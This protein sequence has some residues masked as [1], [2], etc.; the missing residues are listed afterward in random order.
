[1]GIGIERMTKD[2][3]KALR[4]VD[5]ADC[6]LV[7][8]DKGRL[9]KCETPIG[10]SREH[11]TPLVIESGDQLL[12]LADAWNYPEA[13]EGVFDTIHTG[14][15]R[16]IVCVPD[17]IP[18]LHP[19]ACHERTV[20]LYRPW[21]REILLGAD[22]VLSISRAA[23]DDLVSVVADRNIPHRPGLPVDWFH[24]AS[25]FEPRAEVNV[26]EKIRQSFEDD[27]RVYLCVGT[28]EPRKGHLVAVEAFEKL[29]ADGASSR[30][31]FVG[32]RGWFDYALVARILQHPEFGKRLFWFD[33]VKDGELSFLYAHMAALVYPSFAEGF[34]LP[35]VEASR[36]GKPVICSDI[37]VFREVGSEGA[38][39]FRVNDPEALAGAIQRWERGAEH[40]DPNRVLAATWSEAAARI[41]DVVRRD[42]WGFRLPTK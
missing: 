39:Y 33:D 24:I 6:L 13:Y 1:M 27:L 16:V 10:A 5:P 31:V 22:G 11:D 15:G 9:L 28:L 41:I 4:E 14:G 25:H 21:L 30:L 42:R 32:R 2:L 29:W 26:R 38:V 36:F 23:R 12:I 35:I 17:V 34:G 3:S 7:R 19:A 40:A 8:C 20:A 37:P 18:E